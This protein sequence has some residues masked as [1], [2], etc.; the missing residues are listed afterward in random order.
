MFELPKNSVHGLVSKMMINGELSAKWD[1]PTETIVLEKV[2]P[3][4]LP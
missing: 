3:T 1:Q 4:A 2:E